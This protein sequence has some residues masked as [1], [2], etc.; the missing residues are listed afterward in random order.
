MVYKLLFLIATLFSAPPLSFGADQVPVEGEY[1]YHYGDDE[2]VTVAK[3]KSLAFAREVAVSN[4]KVWVQVNTSVKD[5][6]LEKDWIET[7]AVGML[8]GEKR[9][10]TRNIQ[11]ICTAL[12]A[13][14]NPQEVEDFIV[15]Q[16]KERETKQRGASQAVAKPTA[17]DEA[18]AAGK[19]GKAE[20]EALMKLI[21][22]LQRSITEK[23]LANLEKISSM[24]KSRRKWLTTLNA[25]FTTIEIKVG[26]LE[27][28]PDGARVALHFT[29]GIRPNG[30]VVIPNEIGGRFN[31]SVTRSDDRW[32]PIT[33]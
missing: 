11:E 25:N 12:K 9:E 5:F 27:R 3:T 7:I 22:Q 2:S 1:C 4:Y 28:T 8:Q 32:G 18:G 13:W 31:V 26:L 6:E 19:D 24:S 20:T 23:D 17:A 10:V 29:K 14:I 15:Q 33:W 16:K 21:M 30:K